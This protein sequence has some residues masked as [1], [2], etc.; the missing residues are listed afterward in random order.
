MNRK[1]AI[2]II[3]LLLCIVSVA[4]IH[5]VL[6]LGHVYDSSNPLRSTYDYNEETDQSGRTT[7]TILHTGGEFL[8]P[9][10]MII[11]ISGRENQTGT[12]LGLS[13]KFGAGD[14]IT[15]EN[16]STGQNVSVYYRVPSPSNCGPPNCETYDTGQVLQYTVKG[17]FSSQYTSNATETGTVRITYTGDK[18]LPHEKLKIVGHRTKLPDGN[19]SSVGSGRW[20]A[21]AAS[22]ANNTVVAGDTLTTEAQSDYWIEIIH[23]RE[24]GSNR[25]LADKTGKWHESNS[26]QTATPTN[27]TETTGTAQQVS[28]SLTPVKLREFR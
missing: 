23:Q 26:S 9:E 3:G 18:A 24:N 4:G 17:Y 8:E 13:E 25:V 14:T 19:I 2:I 15:I 1:Y 7:L 20:P 16:L 12:E 21:A 5:F 22:G 6:S 27:A 10:R 28:L 11:E